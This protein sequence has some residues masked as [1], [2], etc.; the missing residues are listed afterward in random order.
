MDDAPPL[1]LESQFSQI[2]A[3]APEE[4]ATHQHVAKL[5]RL[6][7]GFVAVAHPRDRDKAIAK[8][9]RFM[10]LHV[11]SDKEAAICGP[12][13]TL[14]DGAVHWPVVNATSAIMRSKGFAFP[15]PFSMRAGRM[16]LC[17]SWASLAEGLARPVSQP[18]HV[19]AFAN[20]GGDGV[21]LKL[22][23][24]AAD[25]SVLEAGEMVWIA[26]PPGSPKAVDDCRHFVCLQTI[27]SFG[28]HVRDA[29]GRHLVPSCRQDSGEYRA[30]SRICAAGGGHRDWMALPLNHPLHSTVAGQH[31]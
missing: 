14:P 2:A 26:L 16:G 10:L 25:G 15:P 7:D 23:D 28:L 20:Q 1:D 24:W 22:R 18:L 31:S 17:T 11:G 19:Q 12:R 9:V 13:T 8:A 27:A 30:I 29:T 6:L 3:S 4:L 5:V 21:V